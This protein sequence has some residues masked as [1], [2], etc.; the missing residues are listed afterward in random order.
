MSRCGFGFV[1]GGLWRVIVL[2]VVLMNGPIS[3]GN[4]VSSPIDGA[5]DPPAERN[6]MTNTRKP[7]TPEEERVIVHRGTEPPFS[8]RFWNHFEPGIY[9]CRRC[10]RALYRSENKFDAGCGWPSFDAEVT[11][12]VRRQPDPDGRRTEI[13]CAGCGAHLGHVFEGE[14]PTIRTITSALERTPPVSGGYPVSATG[15]TIRSRKPLSFP[16]VR[17]SPAPL[18]PL[19]WGF[20]P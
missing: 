9:G 11:G 17:N 2:G 10:G 8:G 12:A 4:G 18:W 20:G 14:R 3:C 7:L 16:Q 5:K 19:W 15:R 1:V 13:V 6:A